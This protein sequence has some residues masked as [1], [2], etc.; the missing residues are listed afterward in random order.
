MISVVPFALYPL[1]CAGAEIT[2]IEGEEKVWWERNH[3]Y[4]GI[5]NTGRR[6]LARHRLG[7]TGVLGTL[8]LAV[9]CSFSRL[10]PPLLDYNNI[11]VTTRIECLARRA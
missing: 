3:P 9:G 1:P 6:A 8:V 11:I 4:L 10:A 2:K 5:A 7:K